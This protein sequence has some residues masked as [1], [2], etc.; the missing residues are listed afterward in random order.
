MSEERDSVGGELALFKVEFNASF[1]KA[2]KYGNLVLS[3]VVLGLFHEPKHHLC[4]TPHPLILG[5]S[6]SCCFGI[7][8]S[9]S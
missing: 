9:L 2:L 3:C 1:F 4:C 8:M 5:G 6:G 7:S